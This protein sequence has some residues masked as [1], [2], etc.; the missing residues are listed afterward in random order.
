MKKGVNRMIQTHNFIHAYSLNS[1]STNWDYC[2]SINSFTEK[3]PMSLMRIAIDLAFPGEGG[4]LYKIYTYLM[5][6]IKHG[7]PEFS[8]KKHHFKDEEEFSSG[9]VNLNAWGISFTPNIKNG[10]LLPI[11]LHTSGN[12]RGRVVSPYP[13]YHGSV[14]ENVAYATAVDPDTGNRYEICDD[15]YWQIQQSPIA[16][17]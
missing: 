11:I 10:D 16:S 2:E 13:L 5:Q 4:D 1:V 15:D 6:L 14:G 9:D 8:Q 17:K 3:H 7:L 12:K